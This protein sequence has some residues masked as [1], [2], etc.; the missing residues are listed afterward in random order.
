[1]IFGV[2]VLAIT[3]VMQVVNRFVPYLMSQLDVGGAEVGA[4]FAIESI[5]V[6]VLAALAVFFGAS[7][8]SRCGPDLAVGAV[9]FGIGLLALVTVVVG[10]VSTPL[11][12]L[13]LG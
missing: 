9:G 7:A 10:L 2:I 11:I 1:M 13:F 4:F 6:G 3:A 8:L 12:S 5:V